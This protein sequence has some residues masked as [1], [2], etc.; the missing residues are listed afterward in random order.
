M[1]LFIL[2][3]W[4]NPFDDD[5]PDGSDTNILVRAP[6]MK[7][8]T[9]L[10]DERFHRIP[11]ECEGLS[12][13]ANFAQCLRQVGEDPIAKTASVVHGPWIEPMLLQVSSYPAWH[14]ADPEENWI[15]T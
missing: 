4:G 5:G 8:A 11:K 7:T 12:P 13:V 10:A 9:M 15:Q 3:R 14:R 1:K 6:D 2:S